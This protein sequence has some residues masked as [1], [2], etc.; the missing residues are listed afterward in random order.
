MRTCCT[1]WPTTP[2]SALLSI[3]SHYLE[4]CVILTATPA[5][6]P[7]RHALVLLRIGTLLAIYAPHYASHAVALSAAADRNPYLACHPPADS[8]NRWEAGHVLA[9]K[10]MRELYHAAAQSSE[11]G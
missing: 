1:C 10:L 3:G 6:S 5:D 9:K 8:F 11:V 2:V 7:H 4:P